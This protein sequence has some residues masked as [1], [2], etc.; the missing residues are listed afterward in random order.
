MLL[1]KTRNNI[2]LLFYY[3]Q[4]LMSAYFMQGVMLSTG[5]RILNSK[6]CFP[7]ACLRQMCGQII[8]IGPNRV[9]DCATNRVTEKGLGGEK[10]G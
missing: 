6:Q 8:T 1:L 10:S 3:S 7:L 2:F 5:D 4:T 9:Y